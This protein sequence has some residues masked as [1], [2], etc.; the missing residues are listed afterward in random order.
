LALLLLS[1][2]DRR[3]ITDADLPFLLALYSDT[4]EDELRPVP[5][6][7]SEKMAFLALQFEAQH[8]HY[9]THYPKADFW[10]LQRAGDPIGRLYVEWRAAEVRLVDIAL[11]AKER[12]RGIGKALMNELIE[13]ADAEQLPI[14][15]HVESHNPAH[16]LY[17]R[18]GFADVE[19]RG[20]YMFMERLPR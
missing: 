15:L 4:R 9:Q 13:R 6:S 5:W 12:G 8:Q 17:E 11:L 10:L 7:E 3:A 20:V 14:R 1:E 19:D 18:L 16:R 2:I